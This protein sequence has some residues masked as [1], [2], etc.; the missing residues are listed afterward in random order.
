MSAEQG[1]TRG[2]R[3]TNALARKRYLPVAPP[4]KGHKVTPRTGSGIAADSDPSQDR[5]VTDSETAENPHGKRD[6]TDVT[7]RGAG[8]GAERPITADENVIQFAGRRGAVRPAT[9]EEDAGSRGPGLQWR[10][11]QAT[12]WE[13]RCDRPSRP[14]RPS[15]CHGG[16]EA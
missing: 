7:D 9:A 13:R 16:G 4:L 11:G 3:V 15:R 10:A 1:V 2:Y 8:D 6:V 12:S 14:S 5:V